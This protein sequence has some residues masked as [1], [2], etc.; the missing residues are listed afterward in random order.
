MLFCYCAT[1]STD[2]LVTQPF[3]LGKHCQIVDPDVR[4][5]GLRVGALFYA[6]GGKCL[7]LGCVRFLGGASEVVVYEFLG[8]APFLF[9]VCRCSGGTFVYLSC[10]LSFF[11]PSFSL[12]TLW[13]WSLL[14]FLVKIRGAESEVGSA[15]WS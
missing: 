7:H 11:S 6:E 10:S 4:I 2:G 3:F 1:V 14:F 8:W 5:T 9:Q 13:M 15:R 12:V